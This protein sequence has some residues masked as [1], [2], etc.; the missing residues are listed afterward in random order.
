MKS[1]QPLALARFFPLVLTD[2]TKHLLL[3]L[4]LD[5][6]NVRSKGK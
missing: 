3:G 5:Y 6:T 1:K 4:F 2:A